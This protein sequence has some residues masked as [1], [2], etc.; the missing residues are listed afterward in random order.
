MIWIVPGGS[1]QNKGGAVN[2][3]AA[4]LVRLRVRGSGTQDE[5][6]TVKRLV[7]IFTFVVLM[8][9]VPGGS[10]VDRLIIDVVT[11]IFVRVCFVTR[12]GS[13]QIVGVGR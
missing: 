11:S 8:I 2:R 7:D 6:G 13:Q 9:K 1:A 3:L 12:L 5:R 4:I 10:A